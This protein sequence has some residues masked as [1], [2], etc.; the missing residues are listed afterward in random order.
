MFFRD[1]LMTWPWR[2]QGTTGQPQPRRPEL[3][4]MVQNNVKEVLSKVNELRPEP[5][6]NTNAELKKRSVQGGVL[7]VVESA[8]NPRNICRMEPTWHPWF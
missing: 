7:N 5:P 2:R 8:L 4:I 3:V 6:P 1:E